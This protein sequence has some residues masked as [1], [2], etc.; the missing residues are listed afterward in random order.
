MDAA[1][2]QEP[3]RRMIPIRSP[4]GDGEVSVLDFGDP[5]R[6]VDVVFLHANGFNALTYRSLLAP[7][8]ASLRVIAPDLRGHGSTRLKADP[9]GRKSWKDFRDDVL[10]LLEVLGG[11]PVTLGG[12]S[13][14]GTVALAAAAHAPDRVS[15]LALFDPVIW[16]RPELALA[17]LPGAQT[18]ARLRIPLVKGALRRRSVFESRTEA[19]QAYRGRGAFA[20]WPETTLADYV[21]GGFAER[22]DGRVELACT[23][24]W[25]ASNFAA[26]ANAPWRNLARTPRPVLILRGDRHSTCHVHDD[27]TLRRRFPHVQVETV[28]GGHFFPMERPDLVRD[29]LLDAAV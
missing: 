27:A 28:P 19:F 14:G 5:T 22:E 10:A 7:L 11:P 8:S 24:A 9:R 21:A 18:V 6:A 29:A 20:T 26:Q 1:R 2:F 23:P 16:S 17:H 12:H 15:N 3:R 25:E 13:M 4:W